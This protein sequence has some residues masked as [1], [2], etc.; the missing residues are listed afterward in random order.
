MKFQ[1]ANSELELRKKRILLGLV[2]SIALAGIITYQH[3]RYP[4]DYNDVL[5]W[6]VVG[7]VV[8]ANMFNYYRHRR[9]LKL[10]K[11]HSIE[12]LDGLLRFTTGDGVS[13]LSLQDVTSMRVFQRR[14][15]LSH[16]QL[17]LGNGRGIRL[18]GYDNMP[19]LAEGL[20]EQ[21]PNKELL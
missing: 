19:A 4:K 8:L 15:Q 20:R 7:F 12:L 2:F 11:S 14:K 16:I 9:Y 3:L 17:Q 5:F 21:L 13:E 1:L 18:E 6:S 10:A